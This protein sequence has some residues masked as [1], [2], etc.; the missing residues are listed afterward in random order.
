[1]RANNAEDDKEVA[2]FHKRIIVVR[3]TCVDFSLHDLSA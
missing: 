1:M 3:F 2:K